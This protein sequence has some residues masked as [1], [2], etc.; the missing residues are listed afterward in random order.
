MRV[1]QIDGWIIDFSAGPPLELGVG[2]YEDLN[3]G[4][5]SP[6]RA[7]VSARCA[8]WTGRYEILAFEIAPD[9]EVES[10]AA[11]WAL[12][13]KK[14]DARVVGAVRFRVAPKLRTLRDRDGDGVHDV[15]DVCPDLP[16]PDQADRDD[17]GLGDAC[18]PDAHVNRIRMQSVGSDWVGKGDVYDLDVEDGVI[19]SWVS[20]DE[21]GLQS[22][23][24]R[25]NT[26][27]SLTT[28]LPRWT[29]RFST[30]LLD[31]PMTFGFYRDAMRFPFE[32]PGRPGI[33]VSGNSSGCNTIDGE[34][35]IYDLALD[36]DGAVPKLDR[37]VASFSQHC[38]GNPDGLHGSILWRADDLVPS[39][40]NGA[41][42]D[43]DGHFDHREDADCPGPTSWLEG[44]ECTNGIDDDAD[45]AIDLADPDCG[46]PW[47]RDEDPRA[48]A[49]GLGPELATLAPLLLW[50]ARRSSRRRR[51][52]SRGEAVR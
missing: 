25:F 40:D 7:A 52:G 38:E 47:S 46:W 42:D 33:A 37:F 3:P 21:D 22:V 19:T 5:A 30:Y 50:R 24:I 39:C 2:V 13:C 20:V 36:L 6:G 34:Y 32:T 27:L 15:A 1:Q 18:D 35:T 45:G 51:A 4:G 49:C 41:D 26:A 17:E 48:H 44:A 16:D 28:G 10:F 23:E 9:G 31:E 29:W 11:D 14:D 8:Y 12:R 43:G